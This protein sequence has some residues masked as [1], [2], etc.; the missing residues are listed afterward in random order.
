MFFFPEIHSVYFK[1]NL[2]C[3]ILPYGMVKC[4]SCNW[5][6]FQVKFRNNT[7]EANTCDLKSLTGQICRLGIRQHSVC[8]IKFCLLHHFSK[9]LPFLRLPLERHCWTQAHPMS[10]TEIATAKVPGNRWQWRRGTGNWA[11]SIGW[12][13]GS[14]KQEWREFT[15]LFA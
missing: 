1:Y 14:N 4:N 9:L 6:P 5:A 2:S 10:G 12:Q 8:S 15:A 13:E 11:Q 3:N 7:K